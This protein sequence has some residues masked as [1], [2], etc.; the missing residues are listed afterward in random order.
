M[1]RKRNLS[2]LLIEMYIGMAIMKNSREFFQKVKKNYHMIQQFHTWVYEKKKKN[3][4]TNLKRIYTLMFF[5]ALFT[6][7]KIW[8]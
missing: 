2:A 5:L 6:I 4:P 3:R 7:A 1:W 8:N